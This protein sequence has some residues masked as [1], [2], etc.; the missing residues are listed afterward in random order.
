MHNI[1]HDDCYKKALLRWDVDKLAADLGK[2]KQ[3]H[4][5]PNSK[6][7]SS[8]EKYHLCL[9]LTERTPKQIAELKNGKEKALTTQLS[10]TIYAYMNKFFEDKYSKKIQDWR[11][12]SRFA[13]DEGYELNTLTRSQSLADRLTPSI[14]VEQLQLPPAIGWI[15]LGFANSTTT[16]LPPSQTRLIAA[17]QPVTI[18]PKEVPTQGAIVETIEWV[19]IRKDKPQS[20]GNNYTLPAKAGVLNPST[21][22]VI[23]D[24]DAFVDSNSTIPYTRIWA[25][26]G[27]YL[28]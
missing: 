8:I 5:A 17:G 6:A 7:L 21:Q 1:D 11:D 20:I 28:E 12:V 4:F 24:L 26:V 15:W 19:N 3:D 18:S 22:L 2:V 27:L 14:A 16:N 23:L 9:L 13:R 25:K 10:K